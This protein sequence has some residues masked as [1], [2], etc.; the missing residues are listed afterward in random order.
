M[1]QACCPV[2]A[3]ENPAPSIH[4]L[5]LRS[6]DIASISRPGQFLNVRVR[7][8]LDPLLRRPFS[9]YDSH[10]EEIK[11][12]FDVRGAG[13]SI[14]ARAGTGDSLDVLGPLGNP[15][16]VEDNF[17][18]AL[19]VGG[20]LGVAPLPMLTRFISRTD[21]PIHTFVGARTSSQVLPMY[22]ENI[23]VATD[24]GSEGF[25]GTVI[26]LLRQHLADNAYR[27]PKIF[28]C[29]PNAMLRNLQELA[30]E[31][32]IPCEVSL[33]SPMACGVGLCQGCPIELVAAEKKY[34]LICR[35]GPVFD[36]RRIRIP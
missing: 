31:Y 14:L 36:S 5:T 30:V 33:E 16:G 27:T 8:S 3:H 10:E 17:E 11:I 24:D 22:L 7:E 35:D 32:K 18:T 2:T 12:I 34:A 9:V 13:T 29:G 28:A 19:L 1:F 15:Y 20:G 6:P 23:S 4:V 26:D 25:H 21:R